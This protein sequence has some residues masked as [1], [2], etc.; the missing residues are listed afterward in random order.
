MPR[1]YTPDSLHEHCLTMHGFA[2]GKTVTEQTH[3]ADHAASERAVDW[4][5]GEQFQ[6]G[7]LSAVLPIGHPY[8]QVD[9][10]KEAA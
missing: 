7:R 8:S 2:D 5:C 9:E 1:F 10:Q 4:L 3:F 6:W